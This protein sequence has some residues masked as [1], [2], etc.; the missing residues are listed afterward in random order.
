LKDLFF[1]D[2]DW[3]ICS[4]SCGGG[5]QK[6]RRTCLINGDKCL[7]CLEE[8]RLCNESPC[9]SEL[10]VEK[11][12]KILVLVLVQQTILWSDWTSMINPIN[13]GIITE[14]RTRF[15]CTIGSL[16]NQELPQIKSDS[17]V[18]RMCN[19]QER[20]DCQETG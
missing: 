13:N 4:K 12:R 7:E 16:S 1:F 2:I 17:V 3:E 10:M 9:P 18:Y 19:N 14:K 8:T 11:K 20:T 15:V 5:I 6:R